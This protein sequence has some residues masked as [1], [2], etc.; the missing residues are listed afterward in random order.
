MI[1]SLSYHHNEDNTWTLQVTYTFPN[2]EEARQAGID[3]LPE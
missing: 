2:W 3:L 1:Q